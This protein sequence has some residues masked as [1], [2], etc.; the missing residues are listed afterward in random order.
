MST[1]CKNC[2]APIVFDPKSQRVVCHSCDSSFDPQTVDVHE[3]FPDLQKVDEDKAHP[4]DLYK[5]F[6][7]CRVYTCQ[8]CGGEIFIH[9]SE[10]STKCIYCGTSSVNFSHISRE[11]A[12]DLIIPFKVTKGEAVTNIK[13]AMKHRP[14]IPK[15]IKHIEPSI[16][17]GIY[18]PF[19]IVN[20]T[21]FE[22][23]I[24][25]NHIGYGDNSKTIYSIRSGIMNLKNLPVD[26]SVIL[27]DESSQRLEPYN[28]IDAKPFKESYLLGFYS[29]ASDISDE[30]LQQAAN[31]RGVNAFNSQAKKMV[32][33][34]DA[35]VLHC[36][37]ETY[38]DK[39]NIKYALFPV[40][41]VTYFYNGQHNTIMVNGQTGKVVCGLPWNE[42]MVKSIHFGLSALLTILL[43]I[44]YHALLASEG[45]PKDLSDGQKMLGI[46]LFP[47]IFGMFV[48]ILGQMKMKKVRKQLDLT[49]AT[50]IYNFTKKR[51]E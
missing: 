42:P 24:I 6:M 39:N 33:G 21:H 10:A 25:E 18:V 48:W 17:R 49:Q 22:A 8:S 14:F 9:G 31:V 11:K 50:S 29:N 3:E 12:P 5:Q 30:T 20:G 2:A 1:L 44:G 34:H 47:T 36:E 23:A 32:D 4:D 15:A 7:A 16:V 45:A 35:R 41:F 40:W 26:A 43:G 46:I 37:Y 27:S 19:K 38:V 13:K 28:L 51:Q